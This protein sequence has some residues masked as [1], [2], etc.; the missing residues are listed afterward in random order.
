MI[1]ISDIING[2]KE[3]GFN[4]LLLLTGV[5]VIIGFSVRYYL[6]YKKKQVKHQIT[7][8]P[9]IKPNYNQIKTTI[10]IKPLK[11]T[12]LLTQTK[13]IIKDEPKIIVTKPISIT[14]IPEYDAVQEIKKPFDKTQDFDNYTANQTK[15]KEPLSG[16]IVEPKVAEQEI[17]FVNYDL[18]KPENKNSFPLL[19]FPKR[20]TVVRSYR[21][22]NTKRRGYKE[23]S[24]QNSITRYFGKDFLVLGDARLNTGR[25]T[26][27]YEPDIAIVEL[28]TSTNLR[29][30]IEIDEPYAGI[31]RQPT[32]CKGD[33]TNRDNYFIERGWIVVRFTE[34]QVHLFEGQCLKFIAQLIKAIIPNYIIPAALVNHSDC[35]IENQWDI[36]QG[37]KWEKD[38]FRE[39]Y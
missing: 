14:K 24:F 3:M 37:Q 1:V 35:V 22:G 6:L 2:I 13:I 20:D 28:Y 19:R 34:H 12:S 31:S 17:K 32:H 38:K 10:P 11:P 4:Q 30:D 23:E 33:D 5:F 8:M 36:V 26:R 15:P 9:L 25:D 7:N 29:I 18:G 39:N 21:S 27:P 16:T